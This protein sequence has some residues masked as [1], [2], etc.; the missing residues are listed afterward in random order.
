MTLETFTL[1][2]NPS[3]DAYEYSITMIERMG[4][5]TRK[6]AYSVAP[7]GSPPSENIFLGASGME[8]D[9]AIDF[10]I[11]NDGTDKAN[12]SYTSTVTTI[13]EQINYLQGTIQEPGFSASWELTHETGSLFSSAEVFVETIDPV[14]ISQQSPKWKPCRIRL[15]RGQS[16]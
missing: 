1:T 6:N 15:R 7:P 9:I 4:A 2:L 16:I 13:E 10:A 8:Q 11:H 14:L 5:P 12:G 3:T